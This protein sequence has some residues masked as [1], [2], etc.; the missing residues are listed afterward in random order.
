MHRCISESLAE[1][2]VVTSSFPFPSAVAS[3]IYFLVALFYYLGIL[4]ECPL[5]PARAS[6]Y[7]FH[8]LAQHET[9]ESIAC[10]GESMIRSLLQDLHCLTLGLLF[11]SDA[12]IPLFS[13]ATNRKTSFFSFFP[14][15]ISFLLLHIPDSMLIRSSSSPTSPSVISR[16]R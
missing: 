6:Q 13:G 3:I 2:G 8:P 7:A 15:P 4:Q 5:L 10:N 12:V 16:Q 14:V 1:K 11:G 9:D